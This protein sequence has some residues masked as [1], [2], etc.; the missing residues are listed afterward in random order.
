MDAAELVKV[1]VRGALPAVELVGVRGEIARPRPFQIASDVILARLNHLGV[2]GSAHR[3]ERIPADPPE[4]PARDFRRR[5]RRS[6]RFNHTLAPPADKP[7]SESCARARFALCES[8]YCPTCNR[9]RPPARPADPSGQS[10]RARAIARRPDQLRRCFQPRRNALPADRLLRG[11]PPN[12]FVS[13]FLPLK[14]SRISFSSLRRSTR[15]FLRPLRRRPKAQ[16]LRRGRHPSRPRL[17]PEYVSASSEPLRRDCAAQPSIS[18]LQNLVVERAKLPDIHAVFGFFE[19]FQLA[20]AARR[21]SGSRTGRNRS[22]ATRSTRDPHSAA[23]PPARS[24]QH[25]AGD[26]CNGRAARATF[27]PFR[28][29]VRAECAPSS[30]ARSIDPA[31]RW[32]FHW[33][34]HPPPASAASCVCRRVERH[35]ARS[36][37]LDAAHR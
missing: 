28:W 18:L 24:G 20:A 15:L 10:S 36:Q 3:T 33:S 27:G 13:G 30:P 34:G 2:L 8:A 35:I 31:P 7:S 29:R 23:A 17:R 4:H 25:R 37:M 26:R 9:P 32:R 1:A 16:P 21:N 12:A 22:T 19:R 6:V 11:W 14:S 5:I